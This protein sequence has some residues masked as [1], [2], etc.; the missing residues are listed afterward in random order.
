MVV[1]L[2]WI[3]SK[4]WLIQINDVGMFHFSCVLQWPHT[5]SHCAL[6]T[7]PHGQ[8]GIPLCTVT[9]WRFKLHI[10]A[11]HSVLGA[12]DFVLSCC[13]SQWHCSWRLLG[14][15]LALDLMVLWMQSGESSVKFLNSNIDIISWTHIIQRKWYPSPS[16][17]IVI[18]KIKKNVVHHHG[19]VDKIGEI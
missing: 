5:L 15:C 19:I 14:S 7:G 4:G 16:P 3:F 18:W 17:C 6:V 2:I 9:L 1:V 10:W 13:R 12:M 8:L 11:L